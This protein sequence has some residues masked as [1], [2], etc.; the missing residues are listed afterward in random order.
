M[1]AVEVVYRVTSLPAEGTLRGLEHLADVYG[2]RRVRINREEG[3][4]SVE[5]DCTHLSESW[6]R[7]LLR[8]AGV[9]VARAGDERVWGGGELFEGKC[10]AGVGRRGGGIPS[11]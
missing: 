6:L 4:L 11:P 3:T 1:V 9:D 5:Y 8:R 7:A 2:I 10:A